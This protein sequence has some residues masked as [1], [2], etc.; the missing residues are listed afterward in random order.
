M[1]FY[2]Q[3][4]LQTQ[5]CFRS[6]LDVFAAWQLN[7][8]SVL[9]KISPLS[10]L[11]SGGSS[12]V[13]AQGL[14]SESQRALLKRGGSRSNGLSAG[15]ASNPPP[16]SAKTPSGP[17][18]TTR[19]RA[20]AAAITVTG[21]IGSMHALDPRDKGWAFDRYY[22]LLCYTMPIRYLIAYFIT[23]PQVAGLKLT[24]NATIILSSWRRVAKTMTSTC[25]HHFFNHLLH[26]LF[27]LYCLLWSYFRRINDYALFCRILVELCYE[28][29]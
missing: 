16:K 15:R 28:R 14:S 8:S 6:A 1:D 13:G 19:S 21:P 25:S 5:L 4:L 7:V 17:N 27:C 18:V 2:W 23:V 11:S 24:N 9:C 10:L 12:N 20:A 29:I 3:F 26:C 22:L